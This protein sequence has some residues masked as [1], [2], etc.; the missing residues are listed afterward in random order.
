V[1]NIDWAP[2]A[3]L[4]VD[5]SNIGTF[6]FTSDY[7]TKRDIEPLPGMWEKVKSLRPVSFRHKATDDGLFV[8]DPTE[9]WGFVAHELQE[10]LTETAASGHKDEPNVIQSPNLL[11][12]LAVL[13]KGLQEAIGRIETLEGK[14]A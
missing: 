6:A 7:R 14:V 12:L 2:G 10:T 9:R 1:H 3:Q 4:W 11:L 13:A 5:A 8:D